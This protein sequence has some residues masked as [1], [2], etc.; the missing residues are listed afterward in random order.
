MEDNDMTT[1]RDIYDGGTFLGVMRERSDGSFVAVVDEQIFGPFET[2]RQAT[3][4]LLE[5]ARAGGAQ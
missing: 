2:S 5:L 3:D 4:A 1:E